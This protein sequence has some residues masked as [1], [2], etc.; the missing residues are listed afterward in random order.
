MISPPGQSLLGSPADLPPLHEVWQTLSLQ[1]GFNSSVVCI[2]TTLLGIAAGTIGTFSLLRK[3]A[4]VGDA[5]AHSALPGLALA[6][7]ISSLLGVSGRTLWILLSGAAVSG[8]LGVMAVQ[9]LTHYSRLNEDA[10]IG[11]VLSCF[12]GAGIVLISAIQSLGTGQEGGLHHFIY[13]QTA[14]IRTQ[15]AYLTLTLAL[16]SI[17]VSMLFFKEF[18]L[19][20]FDHHFASANGWN[21]TLV[22]L[23]MMALVVAIIIIGLQAVGLLLIVS[24][25]IIP[26]TAARFWTENLKAMTI[27]SGTIGGL[28]GYLGSCLSALLP[29]MPAGAIIVL[30]GGS[31]FFISFFLAPSRGII[32][33]L[34]AHIKLSL[35]IAEEHLLRELAE[36]KHDSSYEYIFRLRQLPVAQNWSLTYR[37]FLTSLLYRKGLIEFAHGV[38]KPLGPLR[39]TPKGIE[40]SVAKVRE[41]RLWECYLVNFA[42]IPVSH[43]DYSADIVEHFISKE[44]LSELEGQLQAR[45]VTSRRDTLPP[46]LHP[47]SG[48]TEGDQS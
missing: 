3:R 4:L 11:A 41:H 48:S 10:A 44:I 13:G 8:V 46:S 17:V 19:V 12:F 33:S 6:F 14:A 31:L 39:L 47:L 26:P 28:S 24:L 22:D 5:L 21:T 35:R 27:V 25:L 40:V 20:A 32:A 18:R 45:N 34:L 37:V 9:A 1:A 30:V 43:V 2:S 29:R 15:D 7:I 38:A 23:L 16:S 42:H 36:K